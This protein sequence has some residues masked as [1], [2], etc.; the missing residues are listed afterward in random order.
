[1]RRSK[2]GRLLALVTGCWL[3]AC[4]Y[5][6]TSGGLIGGIRTLAVPVAENETAES[7]LAEQL[8]ERLIQAYTRDG[9]LRIVDEGHADAVL[10]LRVAAVDDVPFTY[11][12]AEVTEQYRFKIQV[13]AELVRTTDQEQLLSLKQLEGW[14]TYDAALP[15]EEGRDRAVVLALDMIIEELVD[16]TTAGW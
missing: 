10:Y 5:Y 12:A 9:Q 16:R 13:D 1:M 14:S 6:S 11:T 4:A 3:T 2:D 15:D 8:T 7:R